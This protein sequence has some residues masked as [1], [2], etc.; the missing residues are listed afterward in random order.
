MI[1]SALFVPAHRE[2]WVEKAAA[3]GPDAVILDLED[4]VPGAEKDA[5]RARIADA[6]AFL[7]TTPVSALIRIDGPGDLE[8]CVIDGVAALLLPKVE[9]PGT[10]TRLRE[11]WGIS[12]RRAAFR[13][14]RSA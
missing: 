3:A 6:V 8:A 7:G 11:R 10:S 2:G 5:A 9:V 4:S 14:S 12:K 1:R 13:R